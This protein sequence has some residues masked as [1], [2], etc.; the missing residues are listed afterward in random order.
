MK[1]IITIALTLAL[2]G[3]TQAGAINWSVL[4]IQAS[5]STTD[6]S[7]ATYCGYLFTGTDYTAATQYLLEGTLDLEAFKNAAVGTKTSTYVP[8]SS[9]LNIV[10]SP[11]GSFVSESVSAFVVIVDAASVDTAKNFLVAKVNGNGSEYISQTFGETGNKMYAFGAQA[12]NTAWQA[13][14]VPEPTSGLMLL[15]GVAG[16]ALR[17]RRA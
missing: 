9:M 6:K 11:S 16:L 14:A 12:S 17:R 13:V 1:K 3:A 15:I 2:A 10:G 8:A 5:P 7:A 4:N